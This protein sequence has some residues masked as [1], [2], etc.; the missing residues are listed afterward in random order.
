MIVS[1]LILMDLVL[2]REVTRKNNE[3][4][5]SFN[6]YFNGSSTSTNQSNKL[7]FRYNKFQSLF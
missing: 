6:P 5:R 1:I 7:L 3:T 4:Q 2:L